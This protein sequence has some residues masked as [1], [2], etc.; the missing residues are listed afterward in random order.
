M[1]NVLQRQIKRCDRCQR[2]VADKEIP[3][4]LHPVKVVEK[5]WYLVGIDLINAHKETK[6]ANRYIFTQKDYFTK[7]VEAIL[8]SNKSAAAVTHDLYK[9]YCRHGAIAHVISDEGGDLF[10]KK[11]TD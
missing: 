11:L 5:V 8:L 2:T 7:Y 6:Y 9:K 10:C 3:D 4:A 1:P